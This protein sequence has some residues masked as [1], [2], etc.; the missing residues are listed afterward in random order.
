MDLELGRAR[1][2]LVATGADVRLLTGA[3]VAPHV[4]H[5]LTALV[6]AFVALCTLM[7]STLLNGLVNPQMPQQLGWLFEI[8]V[9]HAAGVGAL[10]S[11][12]LLRT[13]LGIVNGV[14]RHLRGQRSGSRVRAPPGQLF[15]G[16][17]EQ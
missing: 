1:Q 10:T 3:A 5:Q 9:T 12:L 16:R 2:H 4:N 7:D 11:Q 15:R 14:S 8:A 6:E 17:P 13:R